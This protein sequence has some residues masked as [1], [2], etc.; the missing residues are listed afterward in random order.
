MKI[1]ILTQPLH[2]NYGGLLQAY[3]LQI[4]LTKMGHE[5]WII[6]RVSKKPSIMRK[7]ASVGKRIILKFLFHKKEIAIFTSTFKPSKKEE[8][9]IASYTSQFIDKQFPKVTKKIILNKD[10]MKLNKQN[11]EA[12]IVGSDQVWRPCYSPCITNYFLDFAENNNSVKKIAYAASFGVNFWEFNEKQTKICS[13][14][15]KKFDAISVR[16][17]SGVALCEKYLKV[18]TTHV[19]D[20]TMLLDNTDYIQLVKSEHEPPVEGDLMTYILDMTPEKKQ[21]I[22]SVSK[23]LGLAPFSVMPKIKLTKKTRDKIDECIYPPVTKW[24]RGFCDAKF[25]ITD[26]FHGCV[27][28]ILFNIPFIVIGNFKRGLARFDSLLK[29]FELEERLLLDVKNFDFNLLNKQIDWQ[30]INKRLN[31]ERENSYNFLQTNLKS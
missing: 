6:N 14:L 26:S 20:P 12:F 7:L 2:N 9:I 25:V 28:S 29:T 5:V 10:L 27:F 21:L 17:D 15:A 31:E 23:K 19:L 1:G 18:S 4:V 24:I 13:R 22:D 11:Y 3:A 16:E 30:Y 8:K